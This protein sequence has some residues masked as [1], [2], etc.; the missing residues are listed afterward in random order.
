VAVR[1]HV[2]GIS[3]KRSFPNT[4]FSGPPSKSMQSDGTSCL[5]L[6]RRAL[7]NPS[8]KGRARV[9]GPSG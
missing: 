5:G 2:A 7:L 9:S 8:S 6:V 4:R 1:T 3:R